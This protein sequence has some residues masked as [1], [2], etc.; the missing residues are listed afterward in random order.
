MEL[1]NLAYGMSA[2]QYVF[3]ETKYAIVEG[4]YDEA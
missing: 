2:G 4:Y 1:Y 3:M